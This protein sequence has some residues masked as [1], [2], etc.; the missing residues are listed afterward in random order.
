MQPTYLFFSFSLFFLFIDIDECETGE[1]QC[2]ENQICRNRNGGYICSCPPGHQLLRIRNGVSRCTDIDEC[3][4]GHPPVCPSNAKCLNTIGSYYCECKSGFQK[5]KGNE[6]IC[7][8]VDEC[9]EIPGLCQQKCVNYWGGY[10]CAC[11][12]GFELSADNRT[13]NDVDECEVHK[14][15]K[16]CMGYCNNVPGSY[17]CSCPR[18]YA[19]TMDK[20]TCRDIDECAT[21]EFCTGR[22]DICTNIH[23][24]Y[25]CTTIHCHYGYVN[26]PD[27]KKYKNKYYL[28]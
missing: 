14:M 7:L 10:R 25:K 5:S 13:C 20:N 12:Q 9:Q 15:Y 19:V 24:S 16:I 8:D 21:G 6:H 1:H 4:Q 23:G 27:Q 2:A 11:N 17:E 18:G 22:N 28:I 26:D 3:D